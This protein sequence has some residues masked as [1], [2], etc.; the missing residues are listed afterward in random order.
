MGIERYLL[1]SALIGIVG[2]RLLRRLC[3]HCKT[4]EQGIDIL[5][6]AQEFSE[7]TQNIQTNWVAPGCDRCSQ[8]GYSG[9]LAVYEVLLI[10]DS[11]HDAILSGAGDT[12]LLAL[13]QKSGMSTLFEDGLQKTMVGDTSVSEVFRVLR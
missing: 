13:A 10:D 3:R 12:E 9:R 1:P 8:T 2:Q 11:F 5:L 4:E 6:Q 7:L